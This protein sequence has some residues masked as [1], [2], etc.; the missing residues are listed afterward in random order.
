[1]KTL[2]G[3]SI[4]PQGNVSWHGG[5]LYTGQICV[6]ALQMYEWHV[7]VWTSITVNLK[8]RYVHEGNESIGNVQ[9][10]HI[11]SAN[12]ETCLGMKSSRLEVCTTH[13][14]RNDWQKPD[15]VTRPGKYDIVTHTWAISPYIESHWTWVGQPTDRM[16]SVFPYPKQAAKVTLGT[17]KG[18]VGVSDNSSACLKI[19]T[20]FIK[21]WGEKPNDI[22][23][24][25]LCSEHFSFLQG[26]WH[27]QTL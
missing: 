17:R 9:Q 1:M 6:R 23:N 10:Y 3:Q 13:C 27:H 12:V 4:I 11:L 22:S 16:N 15:T 25:F 20:F 19:W 14:V 8:V 5:N 7:F 21:H 24:K 18:A 2:L 26:Q